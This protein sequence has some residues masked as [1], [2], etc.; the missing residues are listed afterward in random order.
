MEYTKIKVTSKD[1]A[2]RFFRVLC[3]KGNPNLNELGALIGLSIN[4]WFEHGYMFYKNRQDYI[5][6]IWSEDRY[7]DEE[8][9]VLD[10][11]NLSDLEDHFTYVYD[12]GENWEFDCKVL[13]TKYNYEAKYDDY[14]L[15]MVIE[16]KG[17]GIFENDHTTFWRYL[18]G[19][20]DP[21]SSEE[22]DELMQY[23]PM[24]LDFE[25]YGDFDNPLDLEDMMYYEEDIED[26]VEEM[27]G[28][29]EE[30][31]Y[32]DYDQEG[33]NHAELGSVIRQLEKAERS[34]A[35]DIFHEE[36]MTN[37]FRR[38]IKK[39]DVVEAYQMIFDAMMKMSNDYVEE[40]TD[41]DIVD[42]YES[43]LNKLK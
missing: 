32:L 5:P 7:Y 27:R 28:D 23:L 25:K 6:G 39:H 10:D 34:V 38:L 29:Y 24:N 40:M 3:V 42:V 1:N 15:A 16:G 41:R 21:E 26:I 14:P 4:C 8:V 20:I 36:I 18:D 13:K 35:Y 33:V 30:E 19:E 31:D 17:Q 12:T 2:K 9:R 37:T 22:D 43:E 11:F